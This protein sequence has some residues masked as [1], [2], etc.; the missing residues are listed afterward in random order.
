M[1]S[2]S[3]HRRTPWVVSRATLRNLQCMDIAAH[4]S[5]TAAAAD[6]C[7]CSG[8]ISSCCLLQVRFHP[9]NS[10]LVASGSLDY[11]VRLWDVSTGQCINHH[12]FGASQCA[13]QHALQIWPLLTI[14]LLVRTIGCAGQESSQS[15][16]TPIAQHADAVRCCCRAAHCLPGIQRERGRAGSRFGPQAAHVGVHKACTINKPA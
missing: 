7:S 1:R 9:T 15:C 3:G 12:D 2:L 11:Q 4:G 6:N 8:R 13:L 5:C 16:C 10:N 14:Q